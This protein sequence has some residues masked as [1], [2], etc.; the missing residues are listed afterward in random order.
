MVKNPP[1]MWQTWVQ[2]LGWEDP[3][4]KGMVTHSSVLA[5]TTPMGSGA[6]RI[7]S[8]V[9]QRVGHGWATKHSS[10]YLT[11]HRLEP[12][13]YLPSLHPTPPGCHKFPCVM[14]QLPTSSLFTYGNICIQCYSLDS[15]HPLLSLLCPE[16]HNS[17]H[18]N[19]YSYS[20][21]RFISTIFPDFIHMH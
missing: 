13:S 9:S 7:Q 8:L 18:L 16:V 10:A 5:W 19:C 3:L 15:S 2:S 6:G 17:L 4:E 1:A 20:A 12:P 21:N 14:K 11:S